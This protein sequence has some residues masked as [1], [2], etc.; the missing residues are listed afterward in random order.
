MKLVIYWIL[1][2]MDNKLHMLFGTDVKMTKQYKV[3]LHSVGNHQWQLIV[4]HNLSTL[5]QD[6][7]I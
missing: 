4:Q 5:I 7:W 1:L 2:P 6:Y 3:A